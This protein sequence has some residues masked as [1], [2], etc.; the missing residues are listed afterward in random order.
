MSEQPL[1][2]YDAYLF[3]E[4]NHFRSYDFLGAHL[5]N[6][7]GIDG[8]VFCVWAPN[9]A[10]VRLIGDF[11]SWN[12]TS[13]AMAKT[14]DSGIWSLFIPGMKEWDMYKYEIHTGDGRVLVK[15][16]PY[17]FYSELR[18]G[19]ASKLL[20]LKGFKWNDDKWMER[21]ESANIYESPVSIYEVHAGS[22]KQKPDGGYYTYRE[23][24]EE[25]VDYVKDMGYTHIELLPLTEYPFDGSW[26]YQA[27]GYYSATSRYGSP[28]DLMYFIN[29]CHQEDIG[30]ILDWVPGHFCKDDN[31]LRLFDG[32]ALYEYSDPRKG[33]NYGWGTCHFDLGKPEVQSFLI[34]NAVFWFEKYHI[35]GLRVD[36][37]ASMLYLD[38]ER[39][40]GEWM[41]NKYGGRENLEAVDFIRKL[42][43]AVFEYYSNVMMIAEESTT[44]PLVTAPTHLGG[45]GFNY[46]WNMGWMNDM[47]KYMTMDPIHRK[48][49]H[50]LITFSLMYAYTEN[51]ILPLSHD[52]VVHGKKSLLDKMPGDYWQKFANLRVLL[53]YMAAHPGKKLLFMGGELGQFIEW[54]YDSGLDWLLLEYKMHKEI[55]YFVKAVNDIYM[56]EQALWELDHVFEGFEWIDPNN[57]DQSIIVFMRKG[58][59]QKDTVIIICSFTPVVY[60]NY[61]IGVPYSCGYTEIFNSDWEEFGGSGQKNHGVISAGKQKWQ[62]Q[63]YS[64]EIKV[65]P[66]GVVYFKPA[67]LP[68]KDSAEEAVEVIESE[69]LAIGGTIP[70]GNT[71]W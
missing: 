41:P 61:R 70:Q 2:S 9:A 54:R 25:L 31:G 51:Y 26:G 4:G 67:D 39:K 69:M 21:R 58:K 37:V 28:Y 57:F 17:A 20:S 14:D 47:L 30:V 46:K 59:E 66:L 33:E 49:H 32:T 56:K 48:W 15:S 8:A 62:N 53:G 36:A 71:N 29:K 16:D 7:A 11:N 44:W 55:Q 34:S 43:K 52:E 45:L 12:G 22:W 1:S 35:D 27:T 10:A 19:K 64:I 40:P 42:N 6:I 38:Y 65:P 24:A 23:L 50:N 63:P 5:T 3:R 13:S 18:P 68:E 60:E